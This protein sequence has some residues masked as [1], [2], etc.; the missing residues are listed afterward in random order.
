MFNIVAAVI[1]RPRRIIMD[2]RII[3]YVWMIASGFL[4]TVEGL[5]RP[6]GLFFYGR[7]RPNKCRNARSTIGVKM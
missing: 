3:I 7:P 1:S 6:H 5:Y 4:Q 2:L